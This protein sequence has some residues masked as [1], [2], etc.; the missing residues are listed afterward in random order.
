MKTI[1]TRYV[2]LPIDVDP[3]MEDSFHRSLS[4]E[5]RGPGD[6]WAVMRFSQCLNHDGGW[7]YESSPSNRDDS[8]KVRCRFPLDEAFDR[9]ETALDALQPVASSGG[10]TS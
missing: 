1:P 9:A 7:E 2:V 5:W 8:F 3:D 10:Q 4:V 6:A